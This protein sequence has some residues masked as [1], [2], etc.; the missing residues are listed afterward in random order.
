MAIN[1][2]F[3]T[4]TLKKENQLT[5]PALYIWRVPEDSCCGA[6]YIFTNENTCVC[7]IPGES[8]KPD[9]IGEASSGDVIKCTDS[10]WRRL[11][12]GERIF[13]ENSD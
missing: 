5:F 4:T 2:G 6:I 7:M 13:L 8:Q 3:E 11:A 1:S 10:R 12:V 9:A